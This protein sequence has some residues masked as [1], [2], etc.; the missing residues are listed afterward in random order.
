MVS[1]KRF[2]ECTVLSLVV[3]YSSFSFG[4]EELHIW[5]DKDKSIGIKHAIAEFEKEYD[6]KVI[7]EE[8][9]YVGHS[10][11]IRIAGPTGNGPDIFLLPSDRFGSALAYGLIAPLEFMAKEDNRYLK[12][13]TDSFF[14][15]ND[16]YGMPKAVETLCL[17]YNKTYLKEPYIFLDD[18]FKNF[19]PSKNNIPKYGLLSIWDQLY[20]SYGII[21][22]YGGYIFGKDIMGNYDV[23]DFG[24]NNEASLNALEYL[25]RIYRTHNIPND[26]LIGTRSSRLEAMDKYFLEGQTV[27]VIGGPWLADKYFSQTAFDV[28]VAPL[29]LLPNSKPMHSFIGVKAYVISTWAKNHELAEKFLRFINRDQFAIE[30]FEITYEI[31]PIIEVLNHDS[32]K[33]IELVKAIF[34]QIRCS[35]LMPSIPAMKYVWDI[36]NHNLSMLITGQLPTNEGLKKC[37]NELRSL[38]D[39]SE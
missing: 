28:G 31:P 1:M 17:Y 27:A 15:N 8:S 26:F 38:L 29:P 39:K 33:N 21:K 5:E 10:D 23:K 19:D 9:P 32:V 12:E 37:A 30:R 20:Y 14:F 34:A 25:K 2:I 16:Y 13:A 24:L 3:F 35:E 11:K 7:V 36:F 22:G 4:I 6:C 18:Y